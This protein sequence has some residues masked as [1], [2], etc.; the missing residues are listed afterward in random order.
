MVGAGIFGITAALELRER[1]FR[2]A[3]MDSGPL[4]H[5][6]AASVDIS[7]VI[8]MDY[9][10]DE[11]Y[12]EMVERAL[13]GWQRWNDT[14]FPE[15]LYHNVGITMLTRQPMEPDG[16]E[17]ESYQML[18]KRGHRPERL[19]GEA[20]AWRFPAW[21][22]GVYVDGYF[23]A[24]AGY[25]ESG[26]VLEALL[27]RAQ[28]AGVTLYAGQMVAEVVRQNGRVTGVR[29]ENGQI[30][31]AH[32]VLLA[33][34]AWTPII[35]PELGAVMRATGHPVFYL[36]TADPTLFKHP[37]FTVFAA[38]IAHTGWY[39]FPL[40]PRQG[41]I[42]I[43]NHGVGNPM[44]PVHDRRVVTDADIRSL[45]A[46]LDE[47]L[48]ALSDATIVNTRCCLY[49]DTLDEHFWI[50]RHPDDPNLIVATGGSGHAFKFAPILG[51]LIADAVTG[52]PNRYLP[53]FR[54][55]DLDLDVQGEEAA[56]YHK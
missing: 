15:K 25:V 6:L 36:K 53:K 12:A 56:R 4:P 46:F 20:I 5:S 27:G 52:Q 33:A 45:R 55:R 35:L 14:L 16:Y 48:P 29:T 13:D 47:S 40:H 17:Y 34:G 44:H 42:K 32:K 24:Q 31:N 18:L 26:R 38:D 1:G 39:G 28:E 21:K 11:V 41:I 9:G 43:A 51:S 2:T 22:A 8:R 50:D 37:H 3:V 49:C 54:W 19:T 10:T 30:F 23:H 7:K